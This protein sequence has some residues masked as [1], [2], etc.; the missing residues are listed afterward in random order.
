MRKLFQDESGWK[1][2]SCYLVTYVESKKQAE[3]AGGR[4][5]SMPLQPRISDVLEKC[6]VVNQHLQK[7]DKATIID[8]RIEFI[9]VAVF[10]LLELQ[11][12]ANQNLS[13][14]QVDLIHTQNDVRI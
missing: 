9:L 1:S 8:S 3:E 13:M 2:H 11:R 4:I 14:L 5:T 10:P 7:I 12:G 6:R